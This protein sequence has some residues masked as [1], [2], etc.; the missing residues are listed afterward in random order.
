MRTVSDVASFKQLAIYP[1]RHIKAA[2]PVH[3]WHLVLGW[4]ILP[5]LFYLSEN[6]TLIPTARGSSIGGDPRSSAVH[7]AGLAIVTLICGVVIAS[8]FSSLI[9]LCARMK[10]F[11]AF[12]VLAILSSVWSVQPRQS[13]IS[14][15]VLLIFTVF[16]LY[17]GN[18]FNFQEQFELIML[19]GAVAL[20]LSIALALFVPGIGTSEAGWR[21]IFSHKQNCAAVSTLWL[22]TALHW[23]CA[24]IYQRAFR[25]LYILMCGVLI[26]M[27]RSRTGWALA[28]IALLLTGAIWFI[29]KLPTKELLLV[30]LIAIFVIGGLGYGIYD[31]ST[32]ILST[33]GKDSTLSERTII[34]S[35]VWTEITKRPLLGYGFSAFWKGLYG[36]S[37][38][39]VL[40]SGWDVSQAQDGFLDAWLGV[41]IIGVGLVAAMA[42]QS[43]KNAVR[44]LRSE[45]AAYVRWAVVV[46]LCT[47]LYNIGE[48]SLEVL[49]MVWFLFLLAYVGLN[50]TVLRE[51]LPWNLSH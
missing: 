16:A 1:E 13:L 51:Q 8:R 34:W 10:V 49:H 50:Q 3:V 48:S 39:V 18:R 45:S 27:S 24:G 17:I 43:M 33:A 32:T 44:T 9:S 4:A 35:A 42:L 37:Q 47:L 30:L 28:L 29:Q 38:E 21:G 41:G 26:V 5:P 31:H 23:T 12:P 25:F 2:R 11:V 15:I 20:P 36:P 22:I 14:G 46:I 7:M 6:G 19:V 40:I